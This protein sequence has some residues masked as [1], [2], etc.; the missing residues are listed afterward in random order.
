MRI[1]ILILEF[2]SLKLKYIFIYILTWL[3]KLKKK[4]WTHYLGILKSQK[5]TEE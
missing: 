1:F 3:K 5:I 2:N 4:S